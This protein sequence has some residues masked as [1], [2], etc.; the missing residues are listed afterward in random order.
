MPPQANTI[1]TMAANVAP[2][3]TADSRPAIG[4]ET[5]AGRAIPAACS[6]N[7]AGSVRAMP[8]RP[9]ILPHSAQL[10]SA[11]RPAT[12]QT[13]PP[14]STR[15]DIAGR[16][17]PVT[18]YPRPSKKKATHKAVIALASGRPGPRSRRTGPSGVGA[19]MPDGHWRIQRNAGKARTTASAARYSHASRQPVAG[20]TTSAASAIPVPMPR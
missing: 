4:E 7:A 16:N 3:R 1:A 13:C 6:A 18:M 9:T 10:G 2:N 12:S 20:M 5:S 19:V 8:W 11:A 15:P 14:E 17:V